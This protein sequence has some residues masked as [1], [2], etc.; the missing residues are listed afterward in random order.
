MKKILVILVTI[1]L[2][3]TSLS[4]TVFADKGGNHGINQ[5]PSFKISGSPLITYGRFKLPLAP[6]EKG[7]GAAVTYSNGMIT[8]TKGNIKIE[9]DLYNKKVFVTTGSVRVEDTKSGIFTSPDSKK[10]TVL[11]KY[12]ANKLGVRTNIDGDNVVVTPPE[13]N[14]PSSITLTPV[15]GTVVANTLNTTNLYMTAQAV[16]TANQATGGKAEL[17]VNSKLVATDPA[18]VAADTTV[19]F[20]TSDGTPTNQEL[21]ALIPIGGKVTVRLYNSSGIFVTSKTG[22]PVLRVDYSA[23]VITGITSAV[24]I[25][26]LK[27]INLYITG[28]VQKN[29]ILDVTKVQITD[30]NP[31]ISRVLTNIAPTGSRGVVKSKTMISIS[32]GAADATA[33]AAVGGNDASLILLPGI[34]ITDAAGNPPA[35][36][37]AALTVKLVT[38]VDD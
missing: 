7:M 8:I 13:I 19:T 30:A 20:S 10:M 31:V 36:I 35:S 17:Y 16:I 6:V 15:G 33:L 3:L 9:I 25:P 1:A 27:R 32:L 5:G 11:I 12:I 26:K 22:N 14:A 29:D 24:Y 18:I 4:V 21:Q 23:P 38:A 34:I 37:A 28:T 2:L